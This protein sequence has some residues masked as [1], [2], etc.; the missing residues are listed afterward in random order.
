M[1]AK[2]RPLDLESIK[3]DEVLLAMSNFLKETNL[4]DAEIAQ[5]FEGCVENLAIRAQRR[6]GPTS[7]FRQDVSREAMADSE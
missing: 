4:G 1:W 2:T 5:I 6:P 7:K 3:F